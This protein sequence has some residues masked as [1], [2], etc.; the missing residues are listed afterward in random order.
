MP[1]E[2]DA[3]DAAVCGVVEGPLMATCVSNDDMIVVVVQQQ[4]K[5]GRKPQN[6]AKE[7]L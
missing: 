3:L 4:R 5:K 7:F 1:L 2:P 6:P